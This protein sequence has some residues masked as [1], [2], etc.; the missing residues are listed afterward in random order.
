M[1]ENVKPTG[2]QDAATQARAGE[3]RVIGSDQDRSA[4]G[5]ADA[6]SGLDT[7]KGNV[8]SPPGS[9]PEFTRG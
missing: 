9:G 8:A 5:A 6:A 4:T 2:A 3:A 1:A 7:L